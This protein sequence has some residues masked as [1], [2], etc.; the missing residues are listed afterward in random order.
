MS[1]EEINE[2]DDLGMDDAPAQ[3]AQDVPAGDDMI[4]TGGAGVVYDY[5]TAPDRA[6]APPRID[7]DGKTV[8]IE[9]ADIV[10]P[11]EGREWVKGKTNKNIEYKYCTFVLHYD[12]EG[13]QEFYSGVRVFKRVENGVEKISHPTI[14][15]DRKN[16]A[17]KLMGLY[18]DHK[19][20]DINSVTLKEFMSF[21]NSKPKAEIK[22]DSVENPTTGDIIKKNFVG[23]F[24]AN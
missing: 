11:P 14:M 19:G 16:Q 17:S 13:Q 3:E 9:K 6:K 20:K 2:F 15:R 23:K 8:T 24:I 22:V 7:L 12:V 5:N 10:L 18:A 21:L 1:S 4:A